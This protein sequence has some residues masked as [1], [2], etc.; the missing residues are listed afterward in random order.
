MIMFEALVIIIF[1]LISTL[2]RCKVV[3][4]FLAI[5][6]GWTYLI[7]KPICTV[8]ISVNVPQELDQSSLSIWNASTYQL[9]GGGPG[10]NEDEV[11]IESMD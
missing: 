1:F 10:W 7:M 9:L 2:T 3:T 11:N 5:I 4:G 8:S 6:F